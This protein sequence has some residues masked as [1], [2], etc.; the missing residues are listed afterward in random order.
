M[1]TGKSLAVFSLIGIACTDPTVL[2][3]EVFRTQN[4]IHEHE[5]TLPECKAAQQLSR[6]LSAWAASGGFGIRQVARDV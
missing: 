2:D 1:S 3:D 5:H 4:R 6:A